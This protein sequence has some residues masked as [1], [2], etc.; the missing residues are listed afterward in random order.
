MFYE[1]SLARWFYSTFSFCTFIS[2]SMYDCCPSATKDVILTAPLRPSA[3]SNSTIRGATEPVKY[4]LPVSLAFISNG[5]RGVSLTIASKS[6][7]VKDSVVLSGVF[8]TAVCVA[9][10][11]DAKD[12]HELLAPSGN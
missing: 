4:K 8:T 6:A 11:T 7:A 12:L 2:A 3:V 1:H 9:P 5:F 10:G